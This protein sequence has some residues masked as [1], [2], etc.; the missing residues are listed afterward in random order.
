[1][2]YKELSSYRARLIPRWMFDHRLS[3]MERLVLDA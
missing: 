1:M 3:R 2:D